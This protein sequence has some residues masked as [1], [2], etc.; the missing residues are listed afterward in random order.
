[1]R[2]AAFRSA[3]RVAFAA[4]IKVGEDVLAA[5]SAATSHR[6]KCVRRTGTE[7]EL[8][9]RRA[10]RH[11]G[12]RYRVKNRDLPGS[13]DLANRSRGWAIFVHGCFWHR[14][15]NCKKATTPKTNRAF[16]S[17]KLSCNQDRDKR[18]AASLRRLRF[19]VLILWQ[20]E[21]ESAT[22]LSQR[23]ALFARLC[24]YVAPRRSNG[25]V[26]R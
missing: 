14:H 24:G 25:Q 11:L 9:V 15:N 6:M 18:V 17:N 10:C 13:P 12:M 20:C 16:W 3:S 22:I 26:A 2:R 5:P 7:A 8:C 21:I 19:R 23:L 1:M 4:T